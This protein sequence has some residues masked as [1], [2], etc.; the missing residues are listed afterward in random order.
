MELSMEK[1]HAK[2]KYYS[3]LRLYQ[4]FLILLICYIMRIKLL[5][6]VLLLSITL[7]SWHTSW[8]PMHLILS[9]CSFSI[10]TFLLMSKQTTESA[11]VC[12][13]KG[14][15]SFSSYKLYVLFLLSVDILFCISFSHFELAV[16]ISLEY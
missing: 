12:N 6:F 16:S 8:L 9:Y 1:N 2:L 10:S 14:N 11:T 3:L 15:I 13:I 5:H 7:H 4:Q